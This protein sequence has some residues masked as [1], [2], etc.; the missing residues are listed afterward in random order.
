[1]KRWSLFLVVVMLLSLVP[2]T[3]IGIVKAAVPYVS[4]HDIQY[5]TDPSGDSPYA[6]Q[7]VITSGVVTAVASKGFFIQNGTGAWDGIYVYLGSSPSVNPGDVVEVKG[8]IKEYWGLTE[9]SVSLSYGDYVQVIGSAP[10]P[11]PVLLPTGNVSQEK[12]E[13]VLVKVENV[14]VTDPDLGYGEWE[15]NDGSGTLVV[16][17]LIYAYSPEMG[18][19]FD[20]IIGV[21]YYSYGDFKLE[22]RDA[23]DIK[24]Y[25]PLIKVSS[26]DVPTSGI[27]GMP[28]TITAVL[29]NDGSFD[30]N[31]TFIL[32]IDGSLVLNQTVEIAAGNKEAVSYNWTPQTLGDH[33]IKAEIVNYDVKYAYTTVY[34]NPTTIVSTFSRYYAY[35]YSKQSPFV[36]EL[37]SRFRNLTEEL[38]TYNVDLG[39][40]QADID[41]IES[42]KE[43]MDK[44]HAWVL[45]LQTPYLPAYLSTKYFI[46]TRKA[47]VLQSELIEQLNAIIPVLEDALEKAKAGEEVSFEKPE[48]TKVLIDNAHN[49]YYNSAKM[50]GLI[51]KI[52]SELGW[53]VEVNNEPFTLEKL[54]GYAVVIITNPGKDITDDEAKALQ[55]YVKQGGGLLITG[56]YYKYVYDKS[57]NKVVEAFGIKFN[58]DELKDD[59]KNTGKSYYPIIGIFNLEH[60]SMKYLTNDS[61]M[62]FDGDTLDI[63]GDAVW[64]IRGY[65]TSYAT[66]ESG[67]IIK[68]KGSKPI[69]AAAVEVG[70]GRVVAY[71]S[72]KALTDT[73]FYYEGETRSYIDS[74]WPFLKGVLLWL[75]NQP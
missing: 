7:T 55:E 15:I 43:D 60:P 53:E 5:T 37:Y 48:V 10:L 30:E 64:L 49:Q 27:R 61:E 68:E 18:Q 35:R 17:D 25:V 31:I 42:T 66:D 11:E 26:L 6:G 40:I 39:P 23:E 38:Q 69:I 45:E 13:G 70:E 4:I 24:E 16:D 63:S 32:S 33:T 1:M 58:D 71:G 20:W 57:L 75:V 67:N 12:W 65:E 2:A 36:D 8:Y 50:L 3:G 52:K 44:Y 62:F 9:I 74:N 72:S 21:V 19:K 56:N 46:A 41:R 51:E 73:S 14:E 54:Q 28:M 59:E 34:E 22:P 47:S 29:E